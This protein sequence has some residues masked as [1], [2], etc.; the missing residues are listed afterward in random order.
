MIGIN[1]SFHGGLV[2]I[3]F[4][5]EIDGFGWEMGMLF[6]CIVGLGAQ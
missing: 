4:Q 3:N 1:R 6:L 2:F 5:I